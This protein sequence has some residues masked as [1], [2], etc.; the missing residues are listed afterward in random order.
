MSANFNEDM[1]KLAESY[2]D[3]AASLSTMGAT[4][5]K[6]TGSVANA[7]EKLVVSKEL[8]RVVTSTYMDLC[9]TI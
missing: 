5:G 3:L 6:L 7:M 9:S 8:V 1:L 4:G 2:V